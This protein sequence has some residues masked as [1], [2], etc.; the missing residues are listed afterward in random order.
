[1]EAGDDRGEEGG[2][3]GGEGEGVVEGTAMTNEAVLA[4]DTLVDHPAFGRGRVIAIQG[5]LVHIYY[6]SQSEPCARKM[7]LAQAGDFLR[8][9]PEQ[10]DPWLSNLPPFSYSAKDTAYCMEHGRLTQRQAI[11]TFLGYYPGGFSDRSY[12]GRAGPKPTGER[13]YKLEA[14][15]DWSRSFGGGEGE[16]LLAAGDL[17]ELTRRLLR[18]AQKSNLLHPTFEKP[19]LKDALGVDETAT[20][21]F[22]ALFNAA[23]AP[24]S[25]PLFKALVAAMNALPAGGSPVAA[26]PLVTIFP[27]LA[28]PR[29]HLFV[30]PGV[31][32]EAAKRLGFELNYRSEP[33]W[34]TYRSVLTLANTLLDG[35]REYGAQDFIDIQGFIFATGDP[36]YK[37]DP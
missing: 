16:R 9:A 3:E 12:I 17:P 2:A 29:E 13:A 33:N 6:A 26:W 36:D 37:P 27:W 1:M 25:E 35:L 34:L 24:P 4:K 32:K 21:F 18:I 31:V 11:A 23:N 7:K 19:P 22:Q 5:D 30:R 20:A 14:V 10:T 15:D 28:R 8:V